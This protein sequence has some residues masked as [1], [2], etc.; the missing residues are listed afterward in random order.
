MGPR[1]LLLLVAAG[2]SLCSPLLSAS[3][4]GRKP[5]ESGPWYSLPALLRPGSRGPPRAWGGREEEGRCWVTKWVQVAL[6]LG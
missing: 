2:L 6:Y 5:G 3:T 1:R 4:G